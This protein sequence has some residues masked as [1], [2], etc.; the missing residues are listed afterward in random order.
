MTSS[1]AFDGW[2]PEKLCPLCPSLI[3]TRDLFR[4]VPKCAG[5]TKG[6]Q[7]VSDIILGDLEVN[8]ELVFSTDDDHEASKDG[9]EKALEHN[10]DK[11]FVDIDK[12]F[13]DFEPS[14][15]S[16]GDQTAEGPMDTIF[17]HDFIATLKPP[18]KI[19]EVL[20]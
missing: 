6:P 10:I 12:T 13:V 5:F 9:K 20:M 3:W 4:F 19:Q 11:S 8:T 14:T 15:S 16:N 1:T 18:E 7:T 2:P 17:T